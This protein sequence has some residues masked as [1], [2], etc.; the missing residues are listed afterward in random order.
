MSDFWDF[1]PFRYLIS[2]MSWQ[3]EKK[4]KRQRDKMIKNKNK[5]DKKTKSQND[6]KTTS[7]NDKMTNRQKDKKT[8][9]QRAKRQKDKKIKDKGQKESLVLWRQGS[10]ALLRC[11]PHRICLHF[12]LLRSQLFFADVPKM[13][14]HL[15]KCICV[16]ANVFVPLQMCLHLSKCICKVSDW[17]NITSH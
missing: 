4:T 10:F 11:F 7:Q 16:Y 9:W 2:M 1:R 8:T 6:I 15:C 5:N 12:V 17:L 3:K 13:C 14:L